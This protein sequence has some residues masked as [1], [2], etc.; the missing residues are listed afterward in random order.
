MKTVFDEIEY[1]TVESLGDFFKQLPSLDVKIKENIFYRGQSNAKYKLTPSVFRNRNLKNENKIY[2]DIMTE[3]SQEFEDVKLHN[4]ILSKMQHYGVQTRLLDVTVNALVALYFA[5][6]GNKNED[7]AVFVIKA[8]DNEIKQYDSDVIS[9]LSSLP[10]FNVDEKKD[11]KKLA[12]KA[13]CKIDKIVPPKASSID[14]EIAIFNEDPLIKR[15]LHEI[16]KE[17]PAFENIINPCDLL[18][19]Y[20]FTPR[21]NNARIIRQSGAFMI[22]G[23]GNEEFE[24]EEYA[25]RDSDKS[26]KIIIGRDH[27]ETII[28]Q[29]SVCGISKATLHPELYKVAEYI[30]EKYN[31]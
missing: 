5:C 25:E 6:E 3:C 19:N 26:Y 10:R 30:K 27:K 20:F 18:N 4:E 1:G 14:I 15:L 31:N 22:F 23:L 9:I 13:K 8:K 16:R 29:L 11:I 24:V 2:S 7:G 17:K 12:E 21:K 28:K